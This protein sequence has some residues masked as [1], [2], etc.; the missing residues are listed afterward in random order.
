MK[1]K[2]KYFLPLLCFLTITVIMVIFSAA[3]LAAPNLNN[4]KYNSN[5]FKKQENINHILF[6]LEI[7][8]ITNTNLTN[9]NLKSL[10]YEADTEQDF[11]LINKNELIEIFG[12]NFEISL[13]TVSKQNTEKLILSPRIT[14]SP[15]HSAMM[16]VAEEE[17]LLNLDGIESI[18]S[19]TYTNVFKLEI[20]PRNTFNEETNSV[21]TDLK[22]KTGQGET[23]LETKLNFKADQPY[24]LAVM[25]SSKLNKAKSLTGKSSES[26]NRYFAIYLKARPVGILTLPKLSSSLAGLEKIFESKKL[27]KK[28]VNIL[29]KLAYEKNNDQFHGV[30][31]AGSYQDDSKIKINFNLNEILTKRNNLSVMA[32]IHKNIWLGL[33]FSYLENEEKEI[34]L[35]FSDLVEFSAF[36]LEAG[37]NPFIYNFET[38]AKDF[39][40]YLKAETNFSQ[41]LN[42]A[43]KYN[44][45][46]EKE[47]AEFSFAYKLNNYNFLLG[48]SW[49]LNLKTE[50]AYWLGLQYKF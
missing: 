44:S 46:V 12:D 6:E 47:L 35:K 42:I 2:Q 5:N 36:K 30:S 3:I 26:Q 33:E 14:V 13:K 41:K 31:L 25:K 23:G 7:L 1:N 8:D 20:T 34:A 48:Y 28:E 15:G 9:L 38:E 17:L 11:N 40:W 29:L 22:L 32:P 10:E 21:L 43:L 24:L 27:S 45:L 16:R 39:S 18:D 19:I 4:E 37:F 49:D 50:D